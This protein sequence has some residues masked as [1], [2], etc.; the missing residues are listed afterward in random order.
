MSHF[1]LDTSYLL[2]LELLDDQN[3]AVAREH[4]RSLGKENLK[5]TTTSYVFDEVVTFLNSRQLHTKAVELGNRLLNSSIVTL[6]MIDEFLF[7]EAWQCFIKH[8]DKSYSLTDCV[9]F[10]VMSQRNISS[11]LTFD[12]HFRQAGFIKMPFLS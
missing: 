8:N 5:I 6:I 10:V 11:A 4:W 1:F 7:V 9:Y 12:H 3:H 2:A